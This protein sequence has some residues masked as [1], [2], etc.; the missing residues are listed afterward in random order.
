[1]TTETALIELAKSYGVWGLMAYL[2]YRLVDKWA[3]KF[4]EV[5]TDRLVAEREQTTA[6]QS[7]ATAISALVQTVQ[8]G[9]NEQHEVLLAVRVMARQMERLVEKEAR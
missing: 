8:T 4:L 1:M 3:G 2:A 9:Q 5:S 6:L 7:Q